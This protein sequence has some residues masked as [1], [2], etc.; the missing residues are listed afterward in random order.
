[1][2]K[3]QLQISVHAGLAKKL[4]TR[5]SEIEN[6]RNTNAAF[7]HLDCGDICFSPM[8]RSALA[9]ITTRPAQHQ[10][11]QLWTTHLKSMAAVT[12]NSHLITFTKDALIAM[13]A[14][15]TTT[16]SLP[17]TVD[18][19]ILF[20]G[21]DHN[22]WESLKFITTFQCSELATINAMIHPASA[23][24]ARNFLRTKCA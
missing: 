5:D 8:P 15:M 22:A 13:Q 12:T 18:T 23:T 4:Q 21:S 3:S 10:S 7:E 11:L 6:I 14:V 24:S 16:V 19:V 17:T 20:T 1:M 9:A 2:S